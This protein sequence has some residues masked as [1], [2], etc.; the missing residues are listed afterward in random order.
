[1]TLTPKQES[2]AQAVASGMTQA[3]AYRSAYDASK[4]KPE[5]VQKRASELMANR[6][7]SGRVKSLRQELS[8]R[9]LWSREDSVKALKS[10]TTNPDNQTAL[11]SAV[12]ELN[13]MHGYN[14]PIKVDVDSRV[15]LTLSNAD[16]RL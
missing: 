13:T 1:M 3:D 11:I 10:V 2:F 16:A 14:A 15:V 9:G 4:M 12:K 6:D 8:D 5:T 7:V